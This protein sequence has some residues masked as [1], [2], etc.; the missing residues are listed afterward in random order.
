MSLHE[1]QAKV[2]EFHEAF[3]AVVG[4]TPGVRDQDLRGSLMREE[5]E[6][7]CQAL[8]DGDLV[9]VADGLADLLYVVLGTAVSCGIDLSP[10]FDEVHISNM[11]KRNGGMRVDG[12][13]MKGPGFKPPRIRELLI[14]QGW[15]EEPK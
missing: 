9:E 13:I 1:A 14:A 10:I 2:R 8:A 5:L 12:K 15:I 11:S 3:G 7:T 6:E 4:N